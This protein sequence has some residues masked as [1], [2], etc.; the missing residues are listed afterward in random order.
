[1]WRHI[2]KFTISKILDTFSNNDFINIYRY[3]DT[4]EPIEP[5]FNN[6]LVQA[7]LENIEI[8]KSRLLETESYGYAN[9]G[10]AMTQAFKIL[11]EVH[12]S[13]GEHMF[14]HVIRL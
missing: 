3:N 2:A 8:L 6:T 14:V 11:N 4:T 7:T 9:L 13:T 10:L 5:C 12:Y 1:M